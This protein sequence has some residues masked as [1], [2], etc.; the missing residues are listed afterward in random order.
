MRNRRTIIVRDIG[1]AFPLGDASST[2]SHYFW[3]EHIISPL[4]SRG[5]SWRAGL[6]VPGCRRSRVDDNVV[7]S[8]GRPRRECGEHL[9]HCGRDNPWTA[10]RFGSRA[11][12]Q[13]QR[14][15]G[16]YM[17]LLVAEMRRSPSQSWSRLCS[18]G[19]SPPRVQV[20]L[21]FDVEAAAAP[22]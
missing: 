9:L 19:V 3:R 8:N 12:Y 11:Q 14:G 16:P 1:A 20:R 5:R 10:P 7:Q 2:C 13:T 18:F 21:T 17:R 4:W 22:L 6:L 15:V